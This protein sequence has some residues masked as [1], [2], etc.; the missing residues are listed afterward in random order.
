MGATGRGS[1]DV[2]S[3]AG[4]DMNSDKDTLPSPSVSA[5]AWSWVA[6]SSVVPVATANSSME[7]CSLPSVS[8]AMKCSAALV[9]NSSSEIGISRGERGSST[10][11]TGS[12]SASTSNAGS[13]S[14]TGICS[15]TG[16]G[17]STGTDMSSASGVG[18][19]GVGTEVASCSSFKPISN[20]PANASWV[21][22]ATC[23][24][25]VV[26]TAGS[27]EGSAITAGSS[28]FGGAG[29][30]APGKGTAVSFGRGTG[31]GLGAVLDAF[32]AGVCAAGF[33]TVAT[34][35]EEASP[36][37]SVGIGSAC[38]ATSRAASSSSAMESK[39]AWF[40]AGSAKA[41]SIPC[42]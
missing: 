14:G 3:A 32:G 28:T 18:M 34:L 1:D 7:S 19:E 26:S 36:L 42:K 31:D 8:A 11:A 13:G 12:G 33:G 22:F 9:N 25:L 20:A 17:A 39:A 16:G 38:P 23:F 21:A 40:P 6:S 15:A 37:A 30:E 24:W 10:T 35:A 5:S 41:D 2:F 4:E 27:G 29:S